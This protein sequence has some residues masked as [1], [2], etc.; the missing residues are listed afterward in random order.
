MGFYKPTAIKP[1]T[2]AGRIFDT[3]ECSARYP[4]TG[5]IQSRFSESWMENRWLARL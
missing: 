4:D 1:T 5:V 3:R 2:V